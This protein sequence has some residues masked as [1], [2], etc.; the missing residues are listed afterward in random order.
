MASASVEH[1]VA[2]ALA[3]LVRQRREDHGADHAGDQ[4][5]RAEDAG[6]GGAEAAREDDVAD[7]GGDAVE[8]AHDDEGDG[9]D[10]QERLD[11]ERVLEPVEHERPDLRLGGSGR[12]RR[13]LARD[14][15][16]TR[17]PRPPRRRRRSAASS[18]MDIMPARIGE[19]GHADGDAEHAGQGDRG[20]RR[21]RARWPGTSWPAPW[22]TSRAGTA[23][24]R[25][26]R[27]CSRGPAGSSS[28]ARPRGDAEHAH[29]DDAEAHGD[30]ESA[31]VDHPG[32]R[33]RQRDEGDH[34]H[35][36][37]QA[38][39]LVRD[40]VVVGGVGDDRGV[41]DPQDLDE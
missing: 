30:A 27:S 35:H 39:H 6:V 32:G 17:R 37:Q 34:E 1:Q 3:L 40:A 9:E 18:A 41:A 24:R 19:S 20:R 22:S 25:R 7:P 31:G 23:A 26:C 5:E 38:D 11:G 10:D 15:P 12:R 36:R 29:H 2:H 13:P 14:E 21:W 8:D 16:G 33:Q 28:P 4:H